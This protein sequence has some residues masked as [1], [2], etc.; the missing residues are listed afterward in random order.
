MSERGYI[1]HP[2][3]VGNLPVHDRLLRCEFW[4]PCEVYDEMVAELSEGPEHID[5]LDIGSGNSVFA[6]SLRHLM[7]IQIPHRTVNLTELDMTNSFA[8]S[9]SQ[10]VVARAEHAP[11]A[12]DSFDLITAR[13]V[14]H[15]GENMMPEFLHESSRVLKPNGLLLVDTI[16]PYN[17]SSI[18]HHGGLDSVHKNVHSL[19]HTY[20]RPQ[21]SLPMTAYDAHSLRTIATASGL[22]IVTM[23]LYKNDFPNDL[24]EMYPECIAFLAKKIIPS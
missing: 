17:L 13:W 15:W 7:R 2:R 8:Q 22:E 24:G 1:L 11:F 5:W 18:S 9:D 21:F 12:S 14:F 10:K 19:P 6:A 23:S 16:T 3:G 20:K 4:R